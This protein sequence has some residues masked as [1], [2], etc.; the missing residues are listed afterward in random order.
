[1]ETTSNFCGVSGLASTSS[2]AT[3]IKS[4]RSEAMS[5]MMGA[6]IL[7]G[8]HQVAQKSTSTGLLLDKT[9]VAKVASETSIVAPDSESLIA[10]LQSMC[11]YCQ[12]LQLIHARRAS[13]RRRW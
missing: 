13:A 4:P 7:H 3:V 5:S 12:R 9:S 6:T 2:L 10:V 11:L 8:P 1:M